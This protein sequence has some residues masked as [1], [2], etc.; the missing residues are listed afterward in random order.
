MLELTPV[1]ALM[2]PNPVSIHHGV[3]V[4]DAA[5]V[6]ANRAVGAALVVDDD[7]RAVGVVS[8]SDVLRALNA[9]ADGAAVRGVMSP[10]VIAVQ[11]NADAFQAS[12]VMV[13]CA[14]RRVFVVDDNG[15]P[16]GVVSATD[17]FRALKVHWGQ[18]AGPAAG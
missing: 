7:G 2:T 15:V 16:V 17:L 9:E 10:A 1:S 13:R 3:T 5:L 8:R 18:A 4:R 11:P 12:E 6:L 14:V